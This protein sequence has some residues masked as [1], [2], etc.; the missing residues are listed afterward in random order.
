[1]GSTYDVTNFYF[2]NDLK[3]EYVADF[4]RVLFQRFYDEL[5]GYQNALFNNISMGQMAARRLRRRW[6]RDG[7]L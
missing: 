5:R 6:S 1:M 2:H 3:V 4:V 7:L